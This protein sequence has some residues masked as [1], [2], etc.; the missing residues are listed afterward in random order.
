M[1]WTTA[2]YNTLC[3]AIASGARKVK[4]EDKEVEYRSLNEML[5]IR[6]Q[7][8]AELGLNSG[9]PRRRMASFHKGV[10]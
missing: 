7:M 3:A 1:T 4:Y 5:R 6:K 2:D 9:R 10:N 8:E